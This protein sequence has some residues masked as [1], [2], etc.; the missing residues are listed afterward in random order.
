M[1]TWNTTSGEVSMKNRLLL[2][3][4]FQKISLTN[5]LSEITGVADTAVFESGGVENTLKNSPKQ[6]TIQN[7][8][9]EALMRRATVF[10]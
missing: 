8:S 3:H 4:G 10:A 9:Q 5:V 2:A 1:N 6:S 7:W